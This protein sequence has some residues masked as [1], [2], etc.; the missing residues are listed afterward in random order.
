MNQSENEKKIKSFLTKRKQD[1]QHT[2]DV[3]SDAVKGVLKDLMGFCRA[4]ESTFDLDPRVHALKEG[5]REVYLR[6]LDHLKLSEED[7]YKKYS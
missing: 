7:L 5:R 6:I 2:F 4:S 3:E 1:Y